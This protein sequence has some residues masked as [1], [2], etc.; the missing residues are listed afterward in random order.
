LA[1]I[2]ELNGFGLSWKSSAATSQSY[3]PEGWRSNF[4]TEDQQILCTT[5]KN[6]VVRATCRLG[7]SHQW[8][9]ARCVY[10]SR[11]AKRLF[12]WQLFVRTVIASIE[13]WRSLLVYSKPYAD[14]VKGS[15]IHKACGRTEMSSVLLQNSRCVWAR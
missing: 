9:K 14:I 12:S 5:V 3:A 2:L 1:Y 15:F 13:K 8:Q 10:F 11:F 6:W 4:H 7:F